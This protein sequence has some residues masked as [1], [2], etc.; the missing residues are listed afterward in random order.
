MNITLNFQAVAR[1]LFA[2]I[3]TLNLK[4]GGP[5]WGIEIPSCSS[6]VVFIALNFQAVVRCLWNIDLELQS[7]PLLT[8]NII[9]NTKAVARCLVALAR[10]QI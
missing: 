2:P 10:P 1:C 9:L 8:M 3:I 4:S 5:L 6:L 7:I